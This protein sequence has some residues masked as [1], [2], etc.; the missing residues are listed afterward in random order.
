MAQMDNTGMYQKY[1]LEQVVPMAGGEYK[2]FGETRVQEFKITLTGLTST[3]GTIVTGTDNIE[4]PAGFTVESVEVIADTL[5]TSGGAATLNIGLCRKDR[6]TEIDN[7][8]LVAALAL[9]AI[10]TT[11]EKTILVNGSTGAGALVGTTVGSN[12][13][14]FTANYGT[15]AYTAGVVTVRVKYR[16]P[17]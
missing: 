9:T 17:Q 3:A 1:G 5:A 8:G 14:H 11:G 4:M 10:D 12:P 7:D 16:K 6:T 13:G 15:A 2:T